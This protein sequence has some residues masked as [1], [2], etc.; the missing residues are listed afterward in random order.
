MTK[1]DLLKYFQT[2]ELCVIST[3]SL[4]NKPESAIMCLVTGDDFCF[5]LFTETNTRKFHNIE[6]NKKVALIIGGFDNDP[7]A[8]ITAQ[9]RVL[10]KNNSKIIFDLII[11]LHPKWESYFSKDTKFLKITPKLV[12][13]SDFSKKIFKEF[14][15]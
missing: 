3:C 13:Y 12:H 9:A 4:K 5:Y 8:Q 10:G 14:L 11:K 15:F 2:K 7:S 6:E 1:K